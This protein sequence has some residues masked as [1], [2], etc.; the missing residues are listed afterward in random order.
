MPSSR[1]EVPLPPLPRTESGALRRIGVE[2]EMG[3]LELDVVVAI[4]AAH[5]KGAV[6]TRGRYEQAVIGDPAGPW[7]VEIDFSLLKELGRQERDPADPLAGLAEAG[8][9]LVRSASSWLVPIEVV[10]PPLSLPRLADVDGLIARLRDAGALGTGGG[11][12][13]AFGLQLNPE[14]P[15]TDPD[16]I[17]RY[18]QAFLCL[19]PWLQQRAKVDLTRRLTTFVDPF[20][21]AYIRQVMSAEYRPGLGNLIDDY[22]R[23]NPTRNRALDLLPLFLHL[24]EARVRRV[25]TDPR[26]KP[27]PALHYRLPNCEIDRPGWGL[28]PVWEDWL[29]VEHLATDP[30][31]LAEACQAYSGFLDRPLAGLIDSWA[32]EVTRWIKP[33]E[34]L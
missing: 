1:G 15:A 10:S 2:L 20:E 7:L 34:D 22:L 17:R 21:A 9:D 26:V 32:E 11:I 6:E 31:R 19:F 14:M 3:G 28:R 13:Y 30:E 18:L 23:A 4:V 29:Q 25:V 8:E 33:P 16:T 24:D 12:V 27:R 5:L